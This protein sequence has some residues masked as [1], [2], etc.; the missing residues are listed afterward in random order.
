MAVRQKLTDR[1]V[2]PLKVSY[3]YRRVRNLGKI[4][5]SPSKLDNSVA[6]RSKGQGGAG[7]KKTS[8]LKAPIFGNEKII[9]IHGARAG[10][11]GLVRFSPRTWPI[12]PRC[13]I[14]DEITPAML[15]LQAAWVSDP[16]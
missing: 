8:R 13:R 11:R 9:R 15:K 5:F 6:Q 2:I 16:L 3:P 7:A 1:K 12:K 10:S 4:N 14:L